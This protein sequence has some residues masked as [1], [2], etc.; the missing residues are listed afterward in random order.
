VTAAAIVELRPADLDQLRALLAA[1]HLPGD[2]CA[3]QLQGICG[4]FEGTELIAAGGLEAI[5]P[6]ALL[7]SIVVREE[8]R[9]RGLAQRITSHLLHRAETQ[10]VTAVY[11]LT[12]TAE[13]WFAKF[14]FHRFEREDVPVA[15][16]CTRQFA[17]LCPQSASSMRCDLP[18]VPAAS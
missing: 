15:V 14:G 18:L 9:G 8:F 16:Q 13:A 3:E 6:Y 4:I 5:T 12:E 10:G 2:D 1:S 11:L 17:G 7:R